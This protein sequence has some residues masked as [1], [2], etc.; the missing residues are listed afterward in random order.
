MVRN[1]C[2]SF[3]AAVGL[4]WSAASADQIVQ[5]D[6]L[7]GGTGAQSHDIM[8]DQFDTLGGTRQLDFIQFDF[9]T[10][11]I[12]GYQT[13]GSG[14]AVDILA[15]L[16]A[17]YDFDG[18]PLGQTEALIQSTVTNN[19]PPVAPTVFNTDT[20]QAIRNQ[21]AFLAAWTGTGQVTMHADTFFEV[22]ETPPGVIN[23]GAG[24]TVRYTV[25]YEYSLVPEP[26]SAAFLVVM[27]LTLLRHRRR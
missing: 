5:M 17:D 7:S 10:S 13:D 26:M 18:M 19:G 14:T 3:L 6:I 15:R 20:D 22:S 24:G 27:G 25:T 9:L 21:P 16:T 8:L 4:S 12:G 1:G 11:V 2:L 23:F